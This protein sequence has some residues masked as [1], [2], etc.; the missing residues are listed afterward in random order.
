[1]PRERTIERIDYQRQTALFDPRQYGDK[2]VVIVGLGNIGSNTAIT[3][4]RLGMR[5]IKL[6]DFD[7]VEVHNLTSQAYTVND[8]GQPK[9][10]ALASYLSTLNPEGIFQPICRKFGEETEDFE[11]L[12]DSIMVIAIDTMQGRK[13]IYTMLSSRKISPQLIIDG[14][15]GG[16]QLELYMIN[17]L[18][19]WSTTFSD[20]PAADPCGGRFICYVSVMMGGL[21]ASQVKKYL[22]GERIDKSIM[23]NVDSLQIIKNFSW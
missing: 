12:G 4:A 10:I 9:A 6:Y 14:R 23:I 17:S 13:E 19:G 3:L 15:I 5:R 7:T 1:M 18:A 11:G 16:E 20:N 22:K 21:I 8:I 2:D